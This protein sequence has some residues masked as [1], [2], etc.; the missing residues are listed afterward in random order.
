MELPETNRLVSLFERKESLKHND[1]E[2]DGEV[3]TSTDL[4]ILVNIGLASIGQV[5]VKGFRRNWKI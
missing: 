5:S 1:V 3:P 2:R 4:S